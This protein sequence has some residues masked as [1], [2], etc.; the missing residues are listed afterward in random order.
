MY[1]DFETL[2]ESMHLMVFVYYTTLFIEYN[3]LHIYSKAKS[4]NFLTK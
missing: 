4:S 1:V 2:L 3:I